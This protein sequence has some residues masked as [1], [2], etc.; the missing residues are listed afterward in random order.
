MKTTL[1][2]SF[3]RIGFCALA[4]LVGLTSFAQAG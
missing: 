3:F 1:Q 2:N 4:L